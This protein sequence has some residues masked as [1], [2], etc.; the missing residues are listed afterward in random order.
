MRIVISTDDNNVPDDTAAAFIATVRLVQQF[1]PLEVWWQGAWLTTDASKGY[2][3]TVPL[4]SGD[5]DYSR[6]EYCINDPRRDTFS[7][8]VMLAHA[9]LDVKETNSGCT[10]QATMAY[11][12]TA[13]YADGNARPDFR[14]TTKFVSH[15]GIA[16]TP[17]AIADTAARWL[18]WQTLSSEQWDLEQLARAAGQVMRVIVE[19]PKEWKYQEPTDAERERWRKQ[20]EAEALKAEKLAQMRAEK[21]A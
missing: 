12:P 21:V 8:D 6:L 4:I 9:A 2:V 13:R 17:M 16:P 18:G 10:T 11:H 5:M 14:N 20:R 19:K 3:F 15:H 7:F 1:V